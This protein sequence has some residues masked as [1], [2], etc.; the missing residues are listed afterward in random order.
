MKKRKKSSRL[1]AL[2]LMLALAAPLIPATAVYAQT[3]TVP[4]GF[5]GIYT[6]QDLSDMRNNLSGKYILMNDLDMTAFTAAGDGWQP[7][8]TKTGPFTGILDGNSHSITGFRI[9]KPVVNTVSFVGGLFAYADGVQIRDLNLSANYDVTVMRATRYNYLG[10][11][12]GYG[13]GVHVSGTKVTLKAKARAESIIVGGIIGFADAPADWTTQKTYLQNC[14]T[15]GEINGVSRDFDMGGMA[16]RTVSIEASGCTNSINLYG[17][18]TVE[19]TRSNIGGIAGTVHSFDLSGCTNK[20]KITPEIST[21]LVPTSASA[22]GGGIVGRKII[23]DSLSQPLVTSITGCI[24]QGAV[25]SFQK[26]GLDLGGIAGLLSNPTITNCTNYG[27]VVSSGLQNEGAAGG[28]LARNYEGTINN[29]TNEGVIAAYGGISGG[30]AA[31]NTG[32]IALCMNHADIGAAQYAGGICADNQGTVQQCYNSGIIS[33]GLYQDGACGGISGV[34]TASISDC[35]NT[36]QIVA[37]SPSGISGYNGREASIKNCY[38]VGILNV[39]LWEA[40]GVVANNYG[41][42]EDTYYYGTVTKGTIDNDGTDNSKKLSYTQLLNASSFV[43]FDFTEDDTPA[44]WEI[45]PNSGMPIL[46]GLK[47]VYLTSLTVQKQPL[48]RSYLI[49][50]TA[51]FKGLG[52]KATYSNGK[53]TLI[54]KGFS[55]SSYTKTAGDKTITASYLGKSASFTIHYDKLN[56]FIEDST[57][58]RV[59][60]SPIPNATS[61]RIY[62]ASAAAGPYKYQATTTVPQFGFEGLGYGKVQY[63]KI[64]PMYGSTAGAVSPYAAIRMKPNAPA[65][66]R[67]EIAANTYT[68]EGLYVKWDPTFYAENYE[69][70]YSQNVGGPYTKL[71]TLFEKNSYLHASATKGTRYYYVIRSYVVENGVKIYSDYSGIATGLSL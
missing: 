26:G 14:T 61:V 22:G 55:L 47:E 4:E 2:L 54:D 67:A 70:Y 57:V 19:N 31:T 21:K 9:Y 42:I 71:A 15:S 46:K 32:S 3:T 34:N 11:L 28:I 37:D 48:T 43:G 45:S 53:T 30:I 20:G 56:L 13:K 68:G 24:N 23:S 49:N 39:S 60:W 1:L 44:V 51:S 36:G 38:S 69:L 5:I 16:G 7:I 66:I 18:V 6:P 25:G 35:Y 63:F 17:L 12:I 41:S 50:K 59:D 8:G 40:A 33:D 52:L 29:C 64:R 65:S 27:K 58:I 10:G 62:W